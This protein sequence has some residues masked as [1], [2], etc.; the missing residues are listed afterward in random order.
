MAQQDEDTGCGRITNIMLVAKQISNE[1]CTVLYRQKLFMVK[2][3]IVSMNIRFCN[4][5]LKLAPYGKILN[6]EK[7]PQNAHFNTNYC[8]IAK[9]IRKFVI[10]IKLEFDYGELRTNRQRLRNGIKLFLQMI[11]RDPSDKNKEYRTLDIKFHPI[12]YTEL[13]PRLHQCYAV[14]E[15]VREIVDTFQSCEDVSINLSFKNLYI[16]AYGFEGGRLWARRVSYNTRKERGRW[17]VDDGIEAV[18]CL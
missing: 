8:A 11:A 3:D 4:Q 12:S 18:A 1:A 17:V 14:L 16:K 10:F 13:R 9:N 6:N 5:A 7:H 15:I 2:L